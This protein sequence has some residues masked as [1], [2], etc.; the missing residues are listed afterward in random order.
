ML[1]GRFCFQV[2]QLKG[3]IVAARRLMAV[4]MY[5]CRHLLVHVLCCMLIMSATQ[6]YYSCVR[7]APRGWL[8]R[9]GDQVRVIKMGGAVGEVAA[10]VRPDGSSRTI[11]TV[12]MGSMTMRLKLSDVLPVISQG[13]QAAAASA[14]TAV[15][16]VS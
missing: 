10:D 14:S 1:A 4:A 3:Q 16:V 6:S 13:P 15:H 11:V 8:P 7:T 5:I 12:T 2:T 9:R